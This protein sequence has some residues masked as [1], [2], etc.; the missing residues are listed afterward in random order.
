MFSYQT[1]PSKWLQFSPIFCIVPKQ[2][3]IVSICL[4][5]PEEALPRAFPLSFYTSSVLAEDQTPPCLIWHSAEA[6]GYDRAPPAF[7]SIITFTVV[8]RNVG[9]SLCFFAKNSY[10]TVLQA[11]LFLALNCQHFI[12]W[13]LSYYHILISVSFIIKSYCAFNCIFITCLWYFFSQTSLQEELNI[14][15][16]DSLHHQ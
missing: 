16:S 1:S 6:E 7:S 11:K 13:C 14:V 4:F 5:L 2:Q 10:P 12:S 8:I 15:F 9:L 3:S